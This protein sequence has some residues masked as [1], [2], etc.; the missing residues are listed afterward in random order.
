MKVVDFAM[1]LRRIKQA[2]LDS[3][4]KNDC[5][6][7]SNWEI[8]SVERA[9]LRAEIAELDKVIIEEYRKMVDDL[10][11]S[12]NIDWGSLDKYS[13]ST[14]DCLCG[15]VFRSHTRFVGKINGLVSR[16]SCPKC[17]THGKFRAVYSDPEKMEMSEDDG[18]V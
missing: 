10:Y 16:R 1:V 11:D 4:C 14:I 7:S 6:G 18:K 12:L 3:L 13:E 5:L 8:L 17:G 15:E 9:A 2:R